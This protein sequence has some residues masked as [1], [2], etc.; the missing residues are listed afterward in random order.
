M[1]HVLRLVVCCLHSLISLLKVTVC[2][3]RVIP[4]DTTIVQQSSALLHEQII[5]NFP[6]FLSV[7]LEV[8]QGN[9]APSFCRIFLEIDIVYRPVGGKKRL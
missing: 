4:L 8:L 3:K 1:T 5:C 6:I 2:A 7:V 9:K